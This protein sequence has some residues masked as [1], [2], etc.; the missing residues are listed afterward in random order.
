[1][2]K[3]Q[4]LLGV[5]LDLGWDHFP[6]RRYDFKM[7]ATFVLGQRK[8]IEINTIAQKGGGGKVYVIGTLFVYSDRN[9]FVFNG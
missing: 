8:Y 3:S 4:V 7:D 9:Y 2:R 1:M 6:E 5:C